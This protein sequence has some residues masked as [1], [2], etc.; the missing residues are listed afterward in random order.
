[1]PEGKVA[2]T[3]GK[4]W[5]CEMFIEPAKRQHLLSLPSDRESLRPT[6][7]KVRKSKVNL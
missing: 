2:V 6:Y 5:G 4:R 7:G 3:R 1:M